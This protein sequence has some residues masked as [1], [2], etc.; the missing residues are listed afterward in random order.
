[1]T[2]RRD[3]LKGIAAAALATKVGA[4]AT[5]WKKQV[6]LE[7]FTVRDLLGKDYEGTLAKVAEIGYKEIEPAT[8]YGNMEPKQFRAMLDRYGLSVPSTHVGATEGP[9]LEKQLE[10]FQIMGIQYTEVRGGGGR[11]PGGGGGRGPGGGAPGAGRGPGGGGGGGGRAPQTEESIK[12]Q[13][14]QINQ[15]G[16]IVK[17]FGMKMLIHN[18]TQEFQPFEGSARVPYDVLL[19]ETDPE[20]VAMQL[21]IGWASVAGQDILAMFKKSPGR[22]ELWHVKDAK[23]IKNMTAGMN[24]GE[25]MRAAMLVPVGQ[26]EVDY[27]TIFANASQAGMKHFCIEQ[28]NAADWGDAIAAARVSFTNLTKML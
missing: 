6:G 17:K 24:Q 26:G 10:G 19:A 8:N 3:F 27:K 7:L 13:A 20:L 25:R 9:D 15:H 21:D 2:G 22:F 16:A 12:R 14:Q 23:G 1:M 18:H 28:D 11:G 5:D 4:A